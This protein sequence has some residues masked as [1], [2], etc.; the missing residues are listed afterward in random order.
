MALYQ[1]NKYMYTLRKI[2][3]QNIEMNIS[4]GK[5]YNYVGKVESPKEFE[6]I[7]NGSFKDVDK[8]IV[9]AFIIDENG[10]EIYPLYTTHKNYIMTESG[11]TFAKVSY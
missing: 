6:R 10:K 3:Q 4:L 7:L 5:A 1:T 11:K 2:N 8:D 9:Y